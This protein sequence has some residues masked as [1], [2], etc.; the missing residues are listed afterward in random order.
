V[1][2]G[3]VALLAVVGTRFADALLQ[4]QPLAA[5]LLSAVV[6]DLAVSRLGGELPTEQSLS[7]RLRASLPLVLLGIMLVALTLGVA[8][9]A[10]AGRVD[11]VHAD[12]TSL[13]LGLAR[14]LGLVARRQ[15]PFV[16]LPL[17]LL[18]APLTGPF[19]A[20]YQNGLCLFAAVLTAE[21]A[22]LDGDTKL[23][24]LVQASAAL[25]GA[26]VLHTTRDLVSSVLAEGAV[27][28]SVGTL[29]TSLFD[30]RL[31]ARSLSPLDRTES[32]YAVVLA[33]GLVAA[34][35][36]LPAAKRRWAARSPGTA[37]RGS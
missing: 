30:V 26:V 9:L 8:L 2:V 24:V 1:I 16:L 29:F 17:L 28:F 13:V 15:L 36:L 25:Y 33:A 11:A 37:A 34:A 14:S 22:Y 10:G 35:A 5:I 27:F 12:P 31:G 20:I 19:K 23:S 4:A 7:A 21:L 32:P 6:F 3:V 18:R